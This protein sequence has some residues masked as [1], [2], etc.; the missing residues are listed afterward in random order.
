MSNMDIQLVGRY[1]IINQSISTIY[2][3]SRC[4]KIDFQLFIGG[5]CLIYVICVCLRKVMPKFFWIVQFQYKLLGNSRYP[6]NNLV[7]IRRIL[8]NQSSHRL[9][10]KLVFAY[11]SAYMGTS[12]S[13]QCSILQS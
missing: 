11:F 8:V 7:C 12:E 9:T 6:A 3:A 2:T 13:S 5:S 1:V 10:T 4:K